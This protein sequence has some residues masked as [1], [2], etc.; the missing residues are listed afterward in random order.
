MIELKSAGPQAV[1]ANT[2]GIYSA[3]KQSYPWKNPDNFPEAHP[4]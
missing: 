4:L 2:R 1:C 3:P